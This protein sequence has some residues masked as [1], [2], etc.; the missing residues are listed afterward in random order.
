MAA[1]AAMVIQNQVTWNIRNIPNVKRICSLRLW[2]TLFIWKPMRRKLTSRISGKLIQSLS[3]LFPSSFCRLS[4]FVF[5]F[6]CSSFQ[7]Y[8]LLVGFALC[9]PG[10]P[11]DPTIEAVDAVEA[12]RWKLE[13]V[14]ANPL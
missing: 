12:R 7:G 6:R 1:M 4:G 9:L 2:Y 11:G 5:H 10:D 13:D 3:V 14:A 8:A